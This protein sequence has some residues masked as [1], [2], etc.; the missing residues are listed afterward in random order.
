MT[1]I[2]RSA[3]TAAQ[4]DAIWEFLRARTVDKP[5]HNIARRVLFGLC[6]R[7]LES[8]PDHRVPIDN[9]SFRAAL[10]AAGYGI[11]HMRGT[12]LVTGIDLLPR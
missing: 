12:E 2:D 6:C 4:R 5:G 7:W 1:E 3:C 8:N 10:D 11:R 9:D